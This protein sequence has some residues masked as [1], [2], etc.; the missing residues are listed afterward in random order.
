MRLTPEQLSARN[1]RNV[2]IAGGLAVFVVLIFIT[3]VLRLHQN[4]EAS[5]LEN[6]ER[7]AAMAA[8][9]VN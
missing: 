1:R 3:T 9:G 7:R 6:A 4:I 8:G 5:A 2:M